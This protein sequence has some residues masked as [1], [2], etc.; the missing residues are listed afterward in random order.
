MGGQ[1]ALLHFFGRIQRKQDR[2]DPVGLDLG[3]LDFILIGRDMLE[4][5]LSGARGFHIL[6]GELAGPPSEDVV[7]QDGV[8]H[9]PVPTMDAARGLTRHVQPFEVGLAAVVDF[10]AAVLVMERRID[11]HRLLGDVDIVADELPVHGREVLVENWGGGRNVSEK[12]TD[13]GDKFY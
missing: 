3:L 1:L 7:I 5:Q 13:F 2:S 4:G 11:E 12:E 10:D 9:Q 8:A 6:G